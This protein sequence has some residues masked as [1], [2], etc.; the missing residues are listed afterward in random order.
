MDSHANWFVLG[1]DCTVFAERRESI[2]V[3]GF[4]SEVGV[5]QKVPVVD[6]AMI[7]QEPLLV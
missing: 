6:A 1:S 7:D 4:S 2:S 3:A 5:L